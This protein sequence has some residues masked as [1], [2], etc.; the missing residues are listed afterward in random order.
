VAFLVAEIEK[1]KDW[2]ERVG[3]FELPKFRTQLLARCEEAVAVLT[4]KHA[5]NAEKN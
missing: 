2:A 3:R 5:E 4:A 1:V